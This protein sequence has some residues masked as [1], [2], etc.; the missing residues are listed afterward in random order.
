MYTSTEYLS[1]RPKSGLLGTAC[2]Y[3]QY[4]IYHRHTRIIQTGRHKMA[5]LISMFFQPSDD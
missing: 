1:N 5:L 4:F 2:V 3:C